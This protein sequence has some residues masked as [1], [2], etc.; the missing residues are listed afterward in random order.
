REVGSRSS[1]WIDASRFLTKRLPAT[2]I[3]RRLPWRLIP[4]T[5][6][7][8]RLDRMHRPLVGSLL[9]LPKKEK[10]SLLTGHVGRMVQSSIRSG[11]ATDAE[12]FSATRPSLG[13]LGTSSRPVSVTPA[14]L[15][16]TYTKLP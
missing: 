5:Q 2:W 14:T 16:E 7:K 12:A 3:S 10:P 15:P 1:V 4:R 11:S 6:L 9:R 8:R 13:V